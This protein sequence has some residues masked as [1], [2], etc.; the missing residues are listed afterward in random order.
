M[1]QKC[2][3]NPISEL[4]NPLFTGLCWH[5]CHYSHSTKLKQFCF[6]RFAWI[7]ARCFDFTVYPYYSGEKGSCYHFVIR[8]DNRN[9]S[10][11][12]H[13]VLLH[14]SYSVFH[15]K[16][17]YVFQILHAIF[18]KSVVNLL[19]FREQSIIINTHNANTACRK[20]VAVW[21]STIS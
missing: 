8:S 4:N 15:R 5:F 7:I 9:R 11:W 20:L 18:S 19:L 10:K 14:W 21:V 6:S 2:S 16:L 13:T 1:L 12:I 17:Q 3:K